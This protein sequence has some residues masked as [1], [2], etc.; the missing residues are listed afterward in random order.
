MSYKSWL[1]CALASA[2]SLHSLLISLLSASVAGG[3][4]AANPAP[5]FIEVYNL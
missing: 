3:A 4:A 2:A 1:Y 5:S